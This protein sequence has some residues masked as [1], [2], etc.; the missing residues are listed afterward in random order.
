[1][2]IVSYF[3]FKYVFP[4][5]D[6]PSPSS[7]CT[8]NEKE[9]HDYHRGD[10]QVAICME[11]YRYFFTPLFAYSR[12]KKFE[13][14]LDEDCREE[15]RELPTKMSYWPHSEVA[16]CVKLHVQCPR[17][18][19]NSRQ[20]F[21]RWSTV[22]EIL[23]YSKLSFYSKN[24]Q[25]KRNEHK[26]TISVSNMQLVPSSADK[27]VSR[28]WIRKSLKERR[29]RPQRAF[30]ALCESRITQVKQ[31]SLEIKWEIVTIL[32]YFIWFCLQG[33]WKILTKGIRR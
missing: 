7:S 6:N 25:E 32:S 10:E 16:D 17:H 31:S 24:I 4:T 22:K 28:S 30:S 26:Q 33:E 23:F 5:A 9:D 3:S 21:F 15:I 12:M 27:P 18:T 29:Y 14:C 13:R 1:M 2:I 8:S 11:C 19:T 20:L